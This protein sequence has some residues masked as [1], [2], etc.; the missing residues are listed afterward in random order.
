MFSSRLPPNLAPNQMARARERLRSFIDLTESNPTRVGFAYPATLLAALAAKEALSYEPRA[1]GLDAARA[2]VAD[3]Y[4]RRQLRVPADR[5]VITASTS[6]GYSL[7][8]KLLCN[9]G[10]GVLVPRPSYPLFEHLTRLDGVD[11]APYEL[12]YHGAWRINLE[13]VARAATARTR[14]ILLVS[15]NNPTGSVATAAEGSAIGDLCRARG[16][17]LIGDEVFADYSLS[18][19]RP[20]GP[21]VLAAPV[22]LT[23]SL[24]GLS[25]T[26]G[27]PQVK[28]G[29]IAVAGPDELVRAA[30]DRLEII[31][32]AYL[33]VSTP[34]Q[35]AA[36]RLLTE[37]AAIREQIA[38]RIRTNYDHLASVVRA[39]SACTLLKA[40]A[41]WYAVIQVPA[42]VG[43]EAL[44]LHLLERHAVLVHPGYFF[45]FQRE[46]FLVL[47]L[48]PPLEDFSAGVDRIFAGLEEIGGISPPLLPS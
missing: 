34:V 24:G 11:V 14:A 36:A 32:D 40:E 8:F 29:W 21:S 5:I 20:V 45:D 38:V 23:F 35:L 48:L 17:A 3:D 43:E 10:E 37:G 44:V 16:F 12:E 31:C 15:P 39:Y 2:A 13:S 9:P 19:D 33:S 6:E 30:L 46:A 28:M 27:L 41:G 18:G 7:L 47:S 4:R 22:A 25:K 26:V 1:L 42:T